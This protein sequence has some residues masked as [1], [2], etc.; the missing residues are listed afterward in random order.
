MPKIGVI[1]KAEEI[2]K[3]GTGQYIW[4]AC[5]NCGKE[6]WVNYRFY[7]TGKYKERGMCASCGIHLSKNSSGASKG[8]LDGFGY[9]HI[10]LNKT[11]F[12][13]P[14]TARK[15]YVREHRL[16]V[17]KALGRC[18]QPWEIVHHKGTKYPIGS[19]EDKADNR[20]P[21]NLELTSIEDHYNLR[22][23]GHLLTCPFCKNK[24]KISPKLFH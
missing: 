3:T 4:I 13:Y 21:E 10:P 7:K 2:K 12:F 19:R 1:C 6:H 5:P 23:K 14:M 22:Y 16:V 17:A 9:R 24:I 8:W 18:L 20:Y 15:G 11:D